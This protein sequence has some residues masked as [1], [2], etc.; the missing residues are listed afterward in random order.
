MAP[1]PVARGVASSEWVGE[2]GV[3]QGDSGG[4]ALDAADK[5]VGVVSRGSTDCGNPVYGAVSSWKSWITEV[6]LAAAASGG[7]EP[8]FWAVSGSSDPPP[9][10]SAGIGRQR[11]RAPGRRRGWQLGQLARSRVR[12]R[13]AL[14]GGLCL[15]RRTRAPCAFL[16][17]KL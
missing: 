8:P 1:A 17:G 2:T 6:A 11:R 16:H 14:P 5:V 7:Y 9:P 10:G 13:T 12:Q 15:C 3:C 4:P